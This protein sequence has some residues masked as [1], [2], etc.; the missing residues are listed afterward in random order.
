MA[1]TSD[2][3]SREFTTFALTSTGGVAFNV[4]GMGTGTGTGTSTAA[5][6]ALSDAQFRAFVLTSSGGVALNLKST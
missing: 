6:G 3:N 4:F 2:R 1:L 5:A